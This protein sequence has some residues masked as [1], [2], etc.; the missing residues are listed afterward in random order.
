MTCINISTRDTDNVRDVGIVESN[1]MCIYICLSL[2]SPKDGGGGTHHCVYRRSLRVRR[3]RDLF[4]PSNPVVR[5]KHNRVFA[6][7]TFAY[8]YIFINKKEKLSNHPLILFT[9]T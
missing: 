8:T 2:L 7:F 3:D 4:W 9:C 6:R 5:P 1:N